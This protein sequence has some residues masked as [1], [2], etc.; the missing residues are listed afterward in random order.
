MV[1]AHRSAK[2]IKEQEIL[3]DQKMA[4]IPEL[5]AQMAQNQALGEQQAQMQN[6]AQTNQMMNNLTAQG[7]Q[8]AVEE[9]VA[10]EDARNAQNAQNNQ[11]SP[12][13]GVV[14]VAGNPQGNQQ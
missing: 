9:E 14:T 11:P 4:Q 7:I 2:V 6:E 1:S 8:A 5:E 10:A 12:N 13:Q 3:P